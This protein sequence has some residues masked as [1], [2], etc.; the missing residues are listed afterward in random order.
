MK[1]FSLKDDLNVLNRW[2]I[3]G[4]IF[5]EK[6][7]HWIFLNCKE[8]EIDKVQFNLRKRGKSLDFTFADFDVPIVSKSLK[9]FFEDKNTNLQFIPAEIGEVFDEYYCLNILN[10]EDC[11][12]KEHS[13]Y[14]IWEE[15]N[16]IRPDKAGQFRSIYKLKISEAFVSEYEIFRVKGFRNQIIVSENI[17]EILLKNRISGLRFLECF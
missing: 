12:D 11:V 7:S 6:F 10:E 15:G 17:V 4:I 1:Y 8:I 9:E 2:Y 5:P 3:G 16:I 13:E 14:E